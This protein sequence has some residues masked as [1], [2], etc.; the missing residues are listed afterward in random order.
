LTNVDQLKQEGKSIMETVNLYEAKTNLS[1][2]V[3]Q[4][5]AGEQI[6]IAK[7][8]KPMAMLTPLTPKKRTIRYGLMKGQFEVPADFDAPLPDD[9]IAAFER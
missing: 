9:V 5:N 3:D 4:A 8:G 2:L 1:R 7:G 6:V